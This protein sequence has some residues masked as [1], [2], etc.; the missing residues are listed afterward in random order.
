MDFVEKR[1]GQLVVVGDLLELWRCRLENIVEEHE[2]ILDRLYAANAIYVLGNHDLDIQHCGKDE[3]QYHPLLGQFH[4]TFFRTIGGRKFKFMHGHEHDPF[5]RESFR[6]W[7]RLFS[8]FTYA[9]EYHSNSTAVARDVA[10]D[11][12]LEMG[13][14]IL[15]GWQWISRRFNKAVHEAYCLLPADEMNRLQRPMRTRKMLSRYYHDLLEGLY[16]IA[17]VG[18]THKAG[19]FGQWYFNSG[20][21]TGRTNNFLH[22]RPDGQI[23]VLNWTD[24]GALPN[25]DLIAC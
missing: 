3:S 16:D 11:I 24:E 10:S 20:S 17:I 8:P 23:Q 15:H 25:T 18:H 4:H 22:I 9:L 7:I 1:N 21:W 14:Q 5:I 6:K 2:D 19:Q 12:L 13:E